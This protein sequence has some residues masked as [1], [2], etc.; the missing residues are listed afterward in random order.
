[1]IVIVSAASL[2]LCFALRGRQDQ[3]IGQTVKA[4]AD[5]VKSQISVRMNDRVR[6]L[7]RMARR[8]AVASHPSGAL[9]EDDAS[10]FIRDLPDVLALKWLKPSG[11]IIW[12][13][14][15]NGIRT[16]IDLYLDRNPHCKAAMERARD[17]L[18]PAAT[19]IV[20]I[21]PGRLGFVIYTPVIVNWHFAGFLAA[22]FDAQTCLDGYLQPGIAEGEAISISEGGQQFYTRD[23]FGAPMRKDWIVTEQLDIQGATWAIRVWPTRGFAGRM[24]SPLPGIVFFAGALGALLLGTL[25]F[26]AQ[27][28]SLHAAEMARVNTALKGALDEVKTLEG[29]L[30]ICACCKRVRDDTGYWNQIDSYLQKHTRASFSHSYCPECAADFCRENGYDIPPSIQADLD[31]KNFEPAAGSAK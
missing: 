29:L 25:C 16:K 26:L 3:D 21:Y 11:Y 18:Q 28:F 12:D 2:A 4:G 27:R 22:V 13:V 9:W 30:P 6:S 23:T 5:S 10:N 17:Q 14:S 31:A 7:V 8:W 20:T 1:V 24:V 15:A 19:G